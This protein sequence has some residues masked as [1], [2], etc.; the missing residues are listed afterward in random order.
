MGTKKQTRPVA[1]AAKSGNGLV[2]VLAAAG[3]AV[4]VIGSFI[5]F[6]LLVKKQEEKPKAAVNKTRSMKA[7][8]STSTKRTGSASTPASAKRPTTRSSGKA[9]QSGLM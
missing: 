7:A 1:T 8:G 9:S 5:A 3:A 4:A 2:P 6:K